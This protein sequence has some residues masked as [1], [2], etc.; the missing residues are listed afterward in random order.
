MPAAIRSQRQEQRQLSAELRTQHKTWAEVACAF[1]ERYRV[2]ARAAMRMAHGW[3]QRD[4]ADRWNDRW[5]A[6]PKTFKNFSYWEVWPAPT[7]HAPSLDVLTRLA[8]LYECSISDLLRDAGDFRSQDTAHRD[9]NALAALSDESSMSSV[10]DFISR[11]EST[12]VHEL[13]RTVARWAEH[14]GGAASRRSVL[15]KLSAALSLAAASPALAD[16]D[17][18]LPPA[19]GPGS[20]F[21][22]VWHSKYTYTSTGRRSDFIGEHYVA[23][24]QKGHRLLGE[25]VPASNGSV[26]NLDLSLT[27]S[28]ATGTWSERTSPAGYYRGAVYHGAIQLVIDPM[29]KTM[30]GKWLGFDREFAVCSDTWELRWID[31]AQNKSAQRKY[32]YEA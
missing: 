14:T 23:I 7:G 26:L 22:G 19:S 2:N 5:P 16:D 3:S 18:P 12:D 17:E 28:V 4:A 31:A 9:T 25:S 10:G 6:D 21:S 24:R 15:L 29:G 11:L 20:D 8:E 13:S 30:T 27:G 32:F 1:S